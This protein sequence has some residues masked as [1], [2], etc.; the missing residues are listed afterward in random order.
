MDIVATMGARDLPVGTSGA[1]LDSL[2]IASL[3]Y[4]VPYESVGQCGSTRLWCLPAASNVWTNA[5]EH[6]KYR[7]AWR[8]VY[9]TSISTAA[10]A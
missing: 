5:Y 10:A 2:C 6:A 4:H 9:C 8:I 7:N 1:R 3:W